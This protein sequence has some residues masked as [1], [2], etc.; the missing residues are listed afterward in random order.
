MCTI[1]RCGNALQLAHWSWN[2][3]FLCLNL[4]SQINNFIVL[5]MDLIITIILCWFHH[6]FT[7]GEALKR[8][9]T[10]LY[11]SYMNPAEGSVSLQ[12][13]YIC[14]NRSVHLYI[15]NLTMFALLVFHY[16]WWARE[17]SFRAVVNTQVV[18]LWWRLY[19][20]SAF[21]ILRQFRHLISNTKL[22][23]NAMQSQIR[24]QKKWLTTL[25]S[26][27]C[28]LIALSLIFPVSPRPS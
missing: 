10:G 11:I 9:E 14:R 23:H 7:N 19:I 17:V 2:M 1:W 16:I 6:C 18:C 22:Y 8:Q 12:K 3:H 15:S 28:E 20:F 21:Q 25:E 4:L 27:P 26:S 24:Y 13:Q 5:V